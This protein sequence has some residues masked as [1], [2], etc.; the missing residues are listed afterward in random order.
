[1]KNSIIKT[2]GSDRGKKG[3]VPFTRAGFQFLTGCPGRIGVRAP[4]YLAAVMEYLVSAKEMILSTAEN[5][6][7]ISLQ[8]MTFA[9]IRNQATRPGSIQIE[10]D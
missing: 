2:L 3:R 1:M 7:I 10:M 6:L 8:K 9:C 5:Y 4:I